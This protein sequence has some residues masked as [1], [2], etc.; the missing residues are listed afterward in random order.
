MVLTAKEPQEQKLIRMAF[1]L[2]YE[3]SHLVTQPPKESPLT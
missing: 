1:E 2:C 3:I